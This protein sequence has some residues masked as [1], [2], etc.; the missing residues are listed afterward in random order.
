MRVMKFRRFS[1]G[2][3]AMHPRE[4]EV[5]RILPGRSL[6]ADLECFASTPGAFRR[7]LGSLT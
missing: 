4:S 3:A 7:N 2:A 5:T 1:A 6:A